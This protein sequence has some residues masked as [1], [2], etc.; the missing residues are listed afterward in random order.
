[1]IFLKKR[2]G[3]FIFFNSKDVTRYT[4]PSPNSA[5][6]AGGGFTVPDFL[7]DVETNIE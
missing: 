5:K 3:S 7:R 2:N 1:M 4:K 6:V